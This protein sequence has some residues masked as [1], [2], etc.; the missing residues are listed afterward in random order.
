MR[1]TLGSGVC[2]EAL[3]ACNRTEDPYSS[4]CGFR[5]VPTVARD[6]YRVTGGRHLKEGEIIGVGEDD[7]ERVRDD[8]GAAL[9]EKVQRGLDLVGGQMELSPGQYL[10]V[11][12][13]H[14]AR[15]IPSFLRDRLT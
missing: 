11:A 5:E 15:D 10:I 4:G 8:W 13:T 2:L 1:E 9:L 6:R 3:E 12:I 7:A 14:G